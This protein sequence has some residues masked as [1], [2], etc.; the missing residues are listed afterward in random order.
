MKRIAKIAV[1][2]LA[3][4]LALTGCSWSKAAVAAEVNGTVISTASIDATVS[5]AE[6]LFKQNAIPVSQDIGTA[7]LYDT[8][9]A[10]LID[11]A[12][13]AGE[14][15]VPQDIVN[16]VIQGSPV[17]GLLATD[18]TTAKLAQVEAI[19]TATQLTEDQ[20]GTNC[21]QLGEQLV[22]V[23]AKAEV[24]INPRYGMTWTPTQGM[25]RDANSGSLSQLASAG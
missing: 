7:A 10:V 9:F 13:A 24:S 6:R 3:G 25:V 1:V 17:L 19:L 21:A 16:T 22:N 5:A 4:L 14:L 8:V 18:P 15:A 23:L 11:K 12:S 2:T 20:C